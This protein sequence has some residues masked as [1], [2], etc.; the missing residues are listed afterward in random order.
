MILKT[1]RKSEEGGW[2]MVDG[3]S[4][5]HYFTKPYCEVKNLPF[6]Y[7]EVNDYGDRD[8]YEVLIVCF[9]DNH[10]NERLYLLCNTTYLMNDDGKTIEQIF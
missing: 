10:N 4:R 6:D 9:M 1:R 2:W 3:I 5:V 7:I 8:N